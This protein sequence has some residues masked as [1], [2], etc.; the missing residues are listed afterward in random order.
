M[1][2]LR[3]SIGFAVLL[4]LAAGP[5]AAQHVIVSCTVSTPEEAAAPLEFGL[6]MTALDGID[7]DDEPLPPLPPGQELNA[8]LQMI[9]PPAPLPNR[10]R[11]DMRPFLHEGYQH[12]SLWSMVIE[13]S[14]TCDDYV[15]S[16]GLDIHEPSPYALTII[17]SDGLR[18]PVSPGETFEVPCTAPI[19]IFYWEL[20]YDEQIPTAARSLGG[21]KA[22]FR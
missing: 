8:Y 9:L 16:T 12:I 4:L 13:S 10:W 2:S 11:R 1:R 7:P 21:L 20:R 15:F 22:L 17:G 18:R 6:N 3:L 5:V 14:G 19:M